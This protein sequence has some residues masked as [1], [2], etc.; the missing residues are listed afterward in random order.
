VYDSDGPCRWNVEVGGFRL[1]VGFEAV[2]MIAVDTQH[3][4]DA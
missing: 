2:I 3:A 4:M 1:N